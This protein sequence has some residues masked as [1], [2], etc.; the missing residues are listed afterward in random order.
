METVAYLLVWAL[1]FMFMMRFGCGAHV[2]G[3]RHHGHHGHHGDENGGRSQPTQAVDPVCGMTVATA[4]ARSSF[5][6]GRAWYFCSPACREKFEA[7]PGQY[8]GPETTPA[9]GEPHHAA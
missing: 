4:D 3:H 9:S 7:A 6:G 8:A 2:M 5:F 1:L